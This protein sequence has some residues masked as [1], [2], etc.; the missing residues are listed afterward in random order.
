[1]D[2]AQRMKDYERCYDSTR[3]P[4]NEY[5]IARMDG[6]SFSAFTRHFDKPYDQVFAD[7]M[8]HTAGDMLA[9]FHATLAYTFS[10][11]ITLVWAPKAIPKK[12]NEEETLY[13]EWMYGGR[14][15]K[16][17]TI[18]SGFASANFNKNLKEAMNGWG[19]RHNPKM[20][21]TIQRETPTFDARIFSVPNDIEVMNNLIWRAR[22]C[23][24]NGVHGLAMRDFSHKELHGK[25][26]D[27]KI[28]M[29]NEQGRDFHAMMDEFKF[30][31]LL[32]HKQ[33]SYR[34]D[35]EQDYLRRR[36]CLFSL[37]VKDDALKHKDELLARFT[38]REC[39]SIFY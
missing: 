27:Q 14:V 18:L 36:V 15:L 32:K 37:N 39:V 11:E 25:N 23:W 29:L 26:S 10:D 7:A 21:D 13:R 6:C 30:G 33:L 38:K 2:L 31:A 3:L 4:T 24:R 34:G 22:D 1:M 20:V 19:F 28:E 16:W 35:D 12:E 17:G 5:V 8:T 9:K